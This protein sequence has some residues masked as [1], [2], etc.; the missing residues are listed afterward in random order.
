MQVTAVPAQVTQTPF[1]TKMWEANRQLSLGL[2]AVSEDPMGVDVTISAAGS[3]EQ[4]LVAGLAL[5][6]PAGAKAQAE[7]AVG[8]VAKA[9][10]TL[11]AAD[12]DGYPTQLEQGVSQVRAAMELIDS[13]RAAAGAS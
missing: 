3:A 2:L 11:A 4:L 12:D 6:A 7:L 1:Q 9:K 5:S 8:M 10:V 13:A